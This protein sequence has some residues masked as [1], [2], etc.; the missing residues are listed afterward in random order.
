MGQS[1]TGIKLALGE[2]TSQ[3]AAGTMQWAE[4]GE[5]CSH[6]NDLIKMV[7]DEERPLCCFLYL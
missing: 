1:Q 2:M 5:G 4:G 7:F 6:L 3:T